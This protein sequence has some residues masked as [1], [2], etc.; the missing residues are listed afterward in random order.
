[1]E[2]VTA[3]QLNVIQKQLTQRYEHKQTFFQAEEDPIVK[4][5]VEEFWQRI[6]GSKKWVNRFLSNPARYTIGQISLDPYRDFRERIL[7]KWE[8]SLP[9]I[10]HVQTP[11]FPRPVAGKEKTILN[12]L[13]S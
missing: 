12:T 10:P 11:T 13:L 6:V 1:M 5:Y 9:G 4:Q 7:S 8:K 3:E 2:D